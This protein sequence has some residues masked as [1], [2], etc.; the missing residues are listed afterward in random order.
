M[1]KTMYDDGFGESHGSHGVGTET[2]HPEGIHHAEGGFHH[3]FENGG[4]GQQGDA[5][6]QTALR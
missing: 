2:R 1:A 3:H 5:P 6:G 4:N